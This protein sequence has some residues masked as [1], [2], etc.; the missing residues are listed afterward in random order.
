MLW[1]AYSDQWGADELEWLSRYDGLRALRLTNLGAYCLGMTNEFTPTQPVSLL[2]FEVLSNLS[3]RIISGE[4]QPADKFLLDTWAEPVSNNTWRLDPKRACEAV[5]R[6]QISADFETLLSQCNDQELP[7]TVKGFFKTCESDGKALKRLGEAQ[8]FECRDTNT[9]A[10]ISSQ[11]ELKNA[12]FRIGETQ[13]V[14][15]SARVAKFRKAVKSL[16]LGIV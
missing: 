7:E 9:A 8:L 10:V 2:K 16:G 4:P 6:G 3:I 1:M 15:P 13:V 12:C 11:N 5:E 14:A